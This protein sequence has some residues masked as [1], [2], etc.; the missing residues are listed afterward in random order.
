MRGQRVHSDWMREEACQ[1]LSPS[2]MCFVEL[3]R[4]WSVSYKAGWAKARLLYKEYLQFS[5]CVYPVPTWSQSSLEPAVNLPDTHTHTLLFLPHL[6]LPGSHFKCGK[7]WVIT[8]TDKTMLFFFKKKKAVVC[9]WF[10]WRNLS[11]LLVDCVE[12]W[13]A[14]TLGIIF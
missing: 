9:F 2:S 1:K 10:K 14:G 6:F 3:W 8:N 12:I 11:M 7:L 5:A 4:G 13:Q